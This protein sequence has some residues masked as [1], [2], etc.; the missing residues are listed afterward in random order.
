[1]SFKILKLFDEIVEPQLE[2]KI[3]AT[4]CYFRYSQLR[5]R[6]VRVAAEDVR[7]V[8]PLSMASREQPVPSAS[9]LLRMVL[10]LQSHFRSCQT[11]STDP[12]R[13]WHKSA[14]AQP[15]V[16]LCDQLLIMTKLLL[17]NTRCLSLFY[18]Y[19]IRSPFS[20]HV[21]HIIRSGSK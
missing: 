21:A 18:Y 10:W 17:D 19:C 20:S 5:P 11:H 2:K 7:A 6:S 3:P 14:S 1:M 9:L 13:A 16:L 15:R 4:P 8:A 12:R